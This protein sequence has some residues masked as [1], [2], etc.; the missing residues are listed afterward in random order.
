ME[1]L[2]QLEI[3]QVRINLDS[4]ETYIEQLQNCKQD[5]DK[6]ESYIN[7]GDKERVV[8][9]SVKDISSTTQ[10]IN[11]SYKLKLNKNNKYCDDL[12]AR[13]RSLINDI[14]IK[15]YHIESVFG[16]SDGKR[17]APLV[18]T[19]YVPEL[20]DVYLNYRS[21]EFRLISEKIK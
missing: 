17:K 7:N 8:L 13:I 14:N 3:D 15:T 10:S 5:I 12:D 20:E 19:G 4:L 11:N 16:K 6:Y 1:S 21:Q 18:N 9:A 2:K